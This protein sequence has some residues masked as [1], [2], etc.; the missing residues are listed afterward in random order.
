MEEELLRAAFEKHYRDV[1]GFTD[2]DLVRNARGHYDFPEVAY[3][4]MGFKAAMNSLPGINGDRIALPKNAKEAEAYARVG[5][6]YLEQHNPDLLKKPTIDIVEEFYKHVH[7]L[8]E[9]L[10]NDQRGK[11]AYNWGMYYYSVL[12]SILEP[13]G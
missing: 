9:G 8:P 4:F 5:L 6:F 2:A 12:R 13:K 3:Q 10:E 7:S 1:E 11:S